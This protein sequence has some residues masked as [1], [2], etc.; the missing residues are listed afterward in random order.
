[1]DVINCA[2]RILSQLSLTP[3]FEVQ[4]RAIQFGELFRL[5]RDAAMNAVP[6]CDVPRFLVE[7]FTE[8]FAGFDMT[9]LAPGV[10]ASI[11]PGDVD[12]DTPVELPPVDPIDWESST[13]E[14]FLEDRNEDSLDISASSSGAGVAFGDPSVDMYY[15]DR[16]THEPKSSVSPSPSLVSLKSFV[17]VDKKPEVVVPRVKVDIAPDETVEGAELG[18]QTAAKRPQGHKKPLF[19]VE[20]S[21]GSERS[22]SAPVTVRRKKIKNKAGKA[23]QRRASEHSHSENTPAA[24]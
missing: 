14:E 7:A 22:D 18:V 2:D 16:Q 15:L 4:E 20:T 5:A 13:E 1:M 23:K 12:L 17:M 8:L 11:Q 21:L 3:N 19:H 24:E 6:D 10:Q 9:P